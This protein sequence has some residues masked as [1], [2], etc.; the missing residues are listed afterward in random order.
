MKLPRTLGECFQLAIRAEEKLSRKNDKQGN[1]RGGGTMRG[2]GV[3]SQFDTS[4]NQDKDKGKE[5]TSETREIF[6]GGR[7]GSGRGN[8][9]FTGKCFTCGGVGNQSYK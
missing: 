5:I 7:F 4:K 2:R 6:R 9:V 3:R 8:S 1:Q